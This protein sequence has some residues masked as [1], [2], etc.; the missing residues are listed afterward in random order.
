M[1]V[2]KNEILKYI[3]KSKD[4]ASWNEVSEM[5]NNYTKDMLMAL[6]ENDMIQPHK[7]FMCGEDINT[8]EDGL[9]K[10]IDWYE[11]EGSTFDN[12]SA[13]LPINCVSK[14][15]GTVCHKCNGEGGWNDE[16]GREDCYRCSGTGQTDC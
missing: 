6:Y 14:P 16:N 1:G 8:I 2:A 5:L 13:T 3:F 4:G 10:L 11:S 7:N 12:S 15:K 9:T